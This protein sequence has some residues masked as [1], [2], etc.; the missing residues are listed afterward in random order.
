MSQDVVGTVSDEIDADGVV[1]S[2]EEGNLQLG[3]YTVCTGD[4]NRSLEVDEVWT[5]QSSKG[6]EVPNYTGIESRADQILDLLFRLVPFFDIYA[7][8]RILHRGYQHPTDRR[9]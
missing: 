4:Q 1:D 9:M 2:R 6:S 8:I 7:G 3:A 5:I